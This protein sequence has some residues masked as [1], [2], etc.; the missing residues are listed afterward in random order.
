MLSKEGKTEIAL[1]K[2]PAYAQ[3]LKCKQNGGRHAEAEEKKITQNKFLK[4]C[5]MDL[6]CDHPIYNH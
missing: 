6:T 2:L 1:G 4:D 5:G 3:C